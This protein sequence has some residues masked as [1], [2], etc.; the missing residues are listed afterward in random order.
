MSDSVVRSAAEAALL[1]RVPSQLLIGG[2][3]VD[4]SGGGT[5]DVEDPA[6]GEVIRTIAD[7]TPEDGL[8]ALD[9]AVEAG[10]AWAAT[11]PRKRAE[12]LRRAF[13]L[14]QERKDDF[15]LLMTLE[16]GKPFAEAL[17]EVAY[18]GEF[19]RW[20]S[21]EA[22]RISGRYGVNPEG[23]GR[24]IVSQH[25]IGPCYLITPWNFPLAMATRKIAP[26]LAAGCTVVVK[27]AE[28][29]PLTTLA[30]AALLAEAGVPDGVVNVVTTSSAGA[31]SEPI[32]SDPRLRKLSFT[33]STPVGRTLLQQAAEGVLRTSMELGG[34]A[35]F[36]VFEDADLDRAVEGAMLAKFR[37][38]GQACTAANRF[39]VHESIAE[40]FAARVTER[41][42]AL[43][44][45][46]GT[47]SG[48]TIGPLIDDRAVEKASSLV[49][50]AVE[51][52]AEVRVGGHGIDGAGHFYE[53]TV[54]AGVAVGS[55]ILHTEIFGPVLAI[56]PFRDE[57]EAVALA[58][59]TEFGLVSYVFTR[60]LARG[61]RMIERLA[62]GMMGLNVGV[63]S[64]AAAPFGGVKQSGLGRE[65]GLE[66]IH[67]YL[68]TKYT[69][70]P[71]PFA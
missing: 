50:D 22:V 18:G 54:L 29:T 63:V 5:I 46:R 17:G 20:F 71:D 67:E 62:T 12:I 64:N 21:E 13:D 70:T 35:P 51:R 19:L 39:F 32:L 9:A 57:D 31:V 42:R 11:A 38:I 4:G 23:T 27:P 26:A 52:G 53:P 30:F 6:T 69:L 61:Q 66:G 49:R 45:G 33:G 8:R 16:M 44:V 14:L 60:D 3:W 28:L 10:P 36:V 56:V 59:D 34:N 2:A 65:G 37:N 25:P 40:E 55:E 24:M 68:S 47:E 58:N 43:T 1:A 7:A 41:V 48:V 15:A